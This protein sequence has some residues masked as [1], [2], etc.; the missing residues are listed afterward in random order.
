M[1]AIIILGFFFGVQP[2]IFWILA[3][4]T[5]EISRTNYDDDQDKI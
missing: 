2:M 4:Y 1:D 3:N 5:I